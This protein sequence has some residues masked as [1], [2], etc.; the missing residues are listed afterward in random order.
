VEYA[1]W[2]PRYRAIAEEFGFPFAGEEHAADLLG[3]LL[4]DHSTVDPERRLRG[5]LAGRTVIVVGLAPGV[6]H[7]P[8]A[9]LP[10]ASHPVATIAA[11]GATARLLGG[12]T[13]P[14]VIA[15]DLDGPVPS[16]ITANA[17]GALAVIHAHGD[18]AAALARWVPEFPGELVGSW[19]GP[20]RPGLIDVG[21][22]TDGDRAAFLAASFGARAVLLF[23][24]DFERVEEADPA[25]AQRKRRKLAWARTLLEV[26]AAE[27]GAP[28]IAWLR[29][30]GTQLPVQDAGVPV[31]PTGPSTQ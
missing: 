25:E 29:P 4:P 6:G 15:T 18:N 30:D 5:R 21:G 7:P 26:L 19:S 31:E 8:I 2:A 14:D 20:P 13:V 17:S 11:D 10:P 27:P 24:F 1:R 3:S 16:E 28:P 22:F 23:G 9:R 12:G